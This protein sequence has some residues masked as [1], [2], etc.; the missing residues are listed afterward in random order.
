MEESF[1]PDECVQKIKSNE[2]EVICNGIIQKTLPSET[3]AG[4]AIFR[5][6]IAVSGTQIQ[7]R[8]PAVTGHAVIEICVNGTKSGIRIAPPY[9]FQL[10]HLIPG[11]QIELSFSFTTTPAPGFRNSVFD[12]DYPFPENFWS[13]EMECLKGKLS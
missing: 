12:K 10:D 1:Q 5:H 6:S 9:H 11:K 4:T 8:F 7:I 2:F 13:W 3:F